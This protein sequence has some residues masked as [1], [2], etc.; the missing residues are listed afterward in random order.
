MRYTHGLHIIRKKRHA[1]KISLIISALIIVLVVVLGF[2]LL[3]AQQF[4]IGFL[5]SLSRVTISYFVA[6]LLALGL[7]FLATA[8]PTTEDV[9]I[10]LLDVMQSFPSFALFP[11]LVLSLGKSS[12]VTIIILV[13]EMIWPILFS[14]VSARK[15]LRPELLEAATIFGAKG[16]KLLTQVL[17]PLLW[18]AI[19]T[20]SIVAWGEAWE[21]IIAAEIIVAVPGVG[22]YLANLG[23]TGNAGLLLV[24]IT[25]LLALLFIINK[26]VWLPLLGSGTAY[27]TD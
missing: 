22:S 8:N 9:L 21:A 13:L 17:F 11:L 5:Q 26:Y 14:I 4:F 6:F 3:D 18:P 24:G 12:V 10:P 27:V 1:L 25:L 19:I 7:A 20:G 15:Q 16:S 23:S 2:K